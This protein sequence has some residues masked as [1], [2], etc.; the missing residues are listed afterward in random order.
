MQPHQVQFGPPLEDPVPENVDL[1]MGLPFEF[2][3]LGQPVNGLNNPE[4]H[5]ANQQQDA[6]DPWPEVNP[7][8]EEPMQLM[9]QDLNEAPVQ[10]SKAKLI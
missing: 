2:F 4:E 3:G 5:L 8:Q 9:F 7:A 1:G 6:W 10:I